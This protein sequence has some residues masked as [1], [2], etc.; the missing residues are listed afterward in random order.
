[1][2]AQSGTKMFTV[3]KFLGINESADGLTELG[4]GEASVM[5]NFFITDAFN[6]TVRPSI[7]RIDGITRTPAKILATWTGHIGEEENEDVDDKYLVVVD[8]ADGKD[9]IF[10]YRAEGGTFTVCKTQNGALGLTSGEM[11][12]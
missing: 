8:F 5:E 1:M 6:L 12:M 11:R 9:R 10:L 2:A 3:D 7:Q 4:M